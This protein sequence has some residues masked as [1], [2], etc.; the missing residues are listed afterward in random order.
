MGQWLREWPKGP[1]PGYK[2]VG[3]NWRR[4]GEKE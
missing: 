3:G 2:V 4:R 1:E